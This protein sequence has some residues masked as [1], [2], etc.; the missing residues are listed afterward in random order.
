MTD[1]RR[2]IKCLTDQTAASIRGSQIIGSVSRAI[3]ELVHNSVEGYAKSCVVSVGKNKIIVSDDGLGIDPEA[4]RMFIGTEYCSNDSHDRV[5][6]KK[7]E[8]LRSIASLCVEM[9]IETACSKNTDSRKRKLGTK[10]VSK[11]GSRGYIIHSEKV[12][13]D[14]VVVSFNQSSG[15]NAISSAIIPIFSD[16]NKEKAGTTIT[17]RG[18]FH[19]HAVRRKHSN[20]AGEEKA[21]SSAELAQIRACLRLL[22]LSYPNIAFKLKNGSTGKVD[23]SYEPPEWAHKFTGPLTSSLPTV[24]ATSPSLSIESRA[25]TLRLCEVYPN[26]FIEENSIELAFE[27]NKDTSNSKKDSSRTNFRVFGALCISDDGDEDIV[28]NRELE[29]VSIN[30]RLATHSD[31]LADIILKLCRGN[32]PS[33]FPESPSI[34]FFLCRLADIFLLFD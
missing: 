16:A 5:I 12:F 3:E 24:T 8:A 34:L 25:L 32:K 7:G 31:K 4:M 14:G 29:V 23:C 22:A 27:E 11:S 10:E 2:Q 30:G 26:E 28:R 20:F 19:R 21:L 15:G 18:L 9:K 1:K 17:I 33:K 6:R 13:K